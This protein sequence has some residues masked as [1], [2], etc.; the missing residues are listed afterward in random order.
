MSQPSSHAVF[1]ERVLVVIRLIPEGRVTTYGLIARA[2][3]QPRSARMV[4]WAALRL[5]DGH[6]LPTHRLVNRVGYLSG[7]WHF[8]HPQV[9]RDLLEDENVRFVDA[10]RVDLVA[11]GWDPADDPDVERLLNGEDAGGLPRAS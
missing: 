9:M 1:M 5:P 8:G 11:C 4:G 3:G 6:D 2:L 10:F 7:G